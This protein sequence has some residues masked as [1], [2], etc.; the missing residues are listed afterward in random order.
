MAKLYQT[1]NA[2]NWN[3]DGVHDPKT[4]RRC[5]MNWLWTVYGHSEYADDCLDRLDSAARVLYPE[6]AT[7]TGKMIHQHPTGAFND[8]PDTT[9]EDV[10]RLCKF[11]DV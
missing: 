3:H 5:V 4:G 1:I 8:H 6:R 11:V 2:E 7:Y 10:L 9:L